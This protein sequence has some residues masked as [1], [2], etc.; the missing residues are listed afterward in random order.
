[1]HADEIGA[2]KQRNVALENEKDSHDRKVTELQSLV[3]AKD[4]ELKDLNVVVSFLKSQNDGLVDQTTCSSLRELSKEQIEEFQDAQMNIVN[5]KV[6]KLDADLLEVD[7]RLLAELSSHKDASAADIMEL[8]RLE[9]P[10]ANAPG[11]S[12]LQPNV[13]Q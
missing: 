10:L 7:L 6:V 3:S 12:D 1:M 13:E 5:D 11:M 8:I 2:L 9:S 4:L